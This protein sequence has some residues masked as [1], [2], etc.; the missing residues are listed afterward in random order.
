M[1]TIL[2]KFVGQVGQPYESHQFEMLKHIFA[3]SKLHDSP[4]RNL[5]VTSHSESTH[6]FLSC[7][8][9]SLMMVLFLATRCTASTEALVRVLRRRSR[10]LRMA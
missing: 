10:S 1:N 8:E 4:A 9:C 5:V 7:K 2:H 6:I 3:K